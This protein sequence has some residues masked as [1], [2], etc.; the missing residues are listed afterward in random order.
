MLE[1]M[2]FDI[3][4]LAIL[5]IL[6]FSLVF[7]KS[8]SDRAGKKLVSIVVVTMVAAL[9][10][11][12]ALFFD[13]K[14]QYVTLNYICTSG[15]LIAR[16]LS[17]YLYT[18]YILI[19]TGSYKKRT[20]TIIKYVRF[21]PL[22]IIIAC[23]LAAPYTRFF[24]YINENAQYVRG[25]AFIIVYICVAV[26]IAH[27]LYFTIVN[28]SNVGRRR[29]LSL[30]SC[31][32]ITVATALIQ[33]ARS[34]II[35]DI[36]GFTISLLF[37]A[38]FI[39]NPDD[40]I[41]STS[42]LMRYQ[43]YVS[44]VKSAFFTNNPFDVIHINITNIK[45]I[46]QILGFTSFSSFIRAF[47]RRLTEVCV[48]NRYDCELYYLKDGRFRIVFRENNIG[49][50]SSLAQ[51][52]CNMTNR[53]FQFNDKSV[54]IESRVSITQCPSDFE[55]RDAFLKFG[56]V[57][58]RFEKIGEVTFASDMLK[59]DKLGILTNID[60]YIERGLLD[61]GFK[62]FFHPIYSAATG[63]FDE[64]EASL[65]LSDREK[66]IIE[67]EYFVP[68]AEQNGAI[69]ELGNYLLDEVCRFIS[70]SEFERTGIKR[71]CVNLTVMQCLQ[72]NVVEQILSKLEKHKVS[73]DKI[74]FEIEEFTSTNNTS[75]YE[76]N[77]NKLVEAGFSIAL[78]GYGS[79]NS[80]I[81]SLSRLP[82]ERVK[83]DEEFANAS[84]N[85]KINVILENSIDMVKSLKK[86]IV[87]MGVSDEKEMNRFIELGCDS[88]QGSIFDVRPMP[89]NMLCMFY[90]SLNR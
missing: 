39:D 22:A 41:E 3:A 17:F 7:K 13:G 21:I 59:E 82:I 80:N 87:I 49:H 30:L 34:Y 88:I 90:E 4:A 9:F 62:A 45:E 37:I 55:D 29:S 40:K 47:S 6:C 24:Y 71:V 32:A 56:P 66:G 57:A 15:Y 46:E 73:P 33:Y 50:T 54:M 48:L 28:I 67:K 5:L 44:F 10:D 74:M 85:E 20:N 86:E 77:I 61:G 81:I 65:K 38:L 42:L 12:G 35:V 26:Y 75:V 70:S 43:A 64:V 89:E 25:E 53:E 14:P 18:V 52:V 11:L 51:I 72:K 78:D 58:E 68:I 19:I 1:T 76:E 27:A 2:Y 8:V 63:K 69:I 84:D 83:F 23:T 36:L 60:K 79:G 31:V 16:I